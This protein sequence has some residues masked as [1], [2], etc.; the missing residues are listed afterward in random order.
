M[1]LEYYYLFGLNIPLERHSLGEIRQPKLIDFINKDV[2]IDNFYFP[3]IMND[4]VIGQSS[5]KESLHRLK[6]HLGSL[7]FMM[8]N[9]YQTKRM[10]ILESLRKSIEMLY[11]TDVEIGDKFNLI[12]GDVIIDD[13]NFDILS[14]LVLE[15]LKIDK[16]KMKFEKEEDPYKDL[17]KEMLEAKR[18]FLDRNKGKSKN[19]D[20]F[21]ILDIANIVIHSKCIEYEKILN[22]TVYQLKNSFEAINVKESFD[23]STLYRIS[24]KFDMSKEKYEH[25]TEKIKID[26]SRL[27]DNA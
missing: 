5:D 19:K 15:I 23:V 4:Y 10:D 22:M 21:T 3:F 14:D 7:T 9:C 1:K 2:D 16:S 17:P 27:G 13:S 18:K 12:V 24:P 25:W 11:G 8:M 20:P 26:K 6:D